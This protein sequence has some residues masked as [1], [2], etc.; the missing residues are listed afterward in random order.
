MDLIRERPLLNSQRLAVA[1]LASLSAA[2]VLGAV[3]SAASTRPVSFA[4]AK[5]YATDEGPAAVALGDLNG[6]GHPD[7]ASANYTA[8][9]VSVLLN[10]GDGTFRTR[11]DYST[12]PSPKALVLGDLNGDGKADLVTA[13]LWDDTISVLLAKGDGTLQAKRDYR[14]AE[15][16]FDVALG[17]LDGDGRLDIAVAADE[18]NMISV[19][20]N[21]GDGSFEASRNYETD[22][23]PDSIAIADM[24]ADGRP[25]LI[26]ANG[27]AATVSVLVNGGDGNFTAGSV[28]DLGSN[29][30]PSLAVGD[31]N[32]DTAPDLAVM[33]SG[34]GLSVLLSR[35]GGGFAPRR[36]YRRW[37][38]GGVTIADLNG[39]GTRDLALAGGY[40]LNRGD[41]GFEAGVEL[42][43]GS[44]GTAGDVNGDGKVDLAAA[45]Y[46][47]D[48][49][50][51][52]VLINTP[53]LCNVQYVLEQSLAAAR[54]TLARGH[55]RVGKLRR[56][57]ST[58]AKKGRVISQK[59]GAGLV[60]PAG[61]KVNLV[62]SKGRRK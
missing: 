61:T 40:M 23:G 15:R 27:A 25:D 5:V 50:W 57:R 1:L 16:P 34:E 22:A 37:Y 53:G 7:L 58:W 46:S 31:L 54:Q 24:N 9:T 11:H 52:A 62:V 60:V 44:G 33:D 51:I 18:S 17:D 8:N 13:N 45:Y 26:T 6:D 55:C 2:F 49:G 56:A 35:Q 59:P 3:G 36:L 30:F 29:G 48:R 19:F 41:G 42:P 28:F 14:T 4:Q 38:G 21:S 43:G 12:A 32:G 20:R 47:S 39:D 10:N